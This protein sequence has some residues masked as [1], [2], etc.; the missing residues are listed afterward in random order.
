MEGL[1]EPT[2]AQRLAFERALREAMA[3]RAR[4]ML[5]TETGV[6]AQLAA[7]RD[8]VLAV[9]AQQ[10]EDWQRLQLTRVLGQLDEILQSTAQGMASGL[11]VG[12]TRLW[13]LGEDAVDKPFAAA[14]RGLE[15]QLGLL[16][17]DVLVALK[18]FA[19]S[20]IRD[21]SAQALRQIRSELDL[22]VLGVQ[23][24]Y[25]A[26]QAVAKVLGKDTGVN[27]RGAMRRA[28][29]IVRTEAARAFAV[30]QHA[31]L[32]QR[33]EIDPLA[34]KRWGKSGKRLSRWNHDWAHGQ[35]REVDEA[36]V[37]PSDEGP[38]KLM[39]PHDVQ[40]PVGQTINC[41]CTALAHLFKTGDRRAQR[42][43]APAEPARRFEAP[44]GAGDANRIHEPTTPAALPDVS[45]PARLAAVAFEQRV[46][47]QALEHGAFFDAKGKLLAQ[48]VGQSSRVGFDDAL[49]ARGATFTHNHPNGGSF[50]M[51]DVLNAAFF[52]L[53]ELRVVTP[54]LRYS[55]IPGD[56]GWPAETE[57]K[58]TM[59]GLMGQAS[60]G[61]VAMVVRGELEPRYA[62]A[63]TQ[64]LLMRLLA[65]RWGLRY[66]RVRS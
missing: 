4:A 59:Q 19:G 1:T 47:L 51:G 9:L 25:R 16:N 62:A 7:A 52:D 49:E 30:A 31:R 6:L 26:M 23:T 50:S 38:V 57:L 61:V 27:A 12:Q 33:A 42:G 46:R 40:A 41:G 8:R 34:G 54:Y 66:S 36:F 60:R 21:V 2:D 17:A 14:G 5:E 45:T 13:Q 48:A 43:G 3:Q 37:L 28:Q 18:T 44:A 29:T 63:E 55:L 65:Q 64:H 39:H 24:P 56:G 53:A 20:R 10:P 22:A 11:T 35:V 58:Q 32:L 15:A